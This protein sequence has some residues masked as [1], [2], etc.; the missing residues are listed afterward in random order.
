[1]IESTL[2]TLSPTIVLHEHYTQ[3]CHANICIQC[4]LKVLLEKKAPTWV[5]MD[6]NLTFV[7]RKEVYKNVLDT[8]DDS[9]LMGTTT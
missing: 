3:Q 9:K 7:I 8:M 6:E 2:P 4:N 5:S 1:M